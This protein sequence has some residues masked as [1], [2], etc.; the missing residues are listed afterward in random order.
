MNKFFI[1]II[2][3]LK[4]DKRLFSKDDNKLLKGELIS[5]ITKDDEKLLNLLASS[6]EVEKRF[7]KKIGKIT[8]FQKEKFLQLVTM[9]EF[10]PD[11]FTAFEVSIGLSDNKKFIS[12]QEDISLVFPHKDCILEGGQKKEDAKRNEIF[13]NT[14]LAPDEIDRLR[15]PKVLTNCKKF[16]KKGEH[17]IENIFKSDNL[18][19]KGNNLLA[20]YSLLP[21]Y[22]NEIKLIYID[23]P[24]NTGSDSFKYNDSFNHSSWLTFMK[25]RLEIALELLDD[26]GGI[27]ISIDDREFAYLKVLCDEIFGQNNFLGD[28]IWNST[29]SITNTA[30]ISVAHTHNLVYFKNINYIIKNRKE[31]RLPESGEGFFNPD[32]DPRGQ[33]KADP[34]QVG[35][36]RPNQQYKIK[37]PNTG[38]I[39]KP[40]DDCS[41]KNDFKKFQE[42]L[43]DNRIVFGTDGKAGPQRKRFLF[44]ALERGKVSKTIWDDVGT[45]TNG[46][47]HLNKLL[48]RNL[49][50][51]PKPETFI[52]KIVELATKENDIVLDFFAG[53]GTTGAVA[54]KMNRQYILIEQMDYVHRLPEARLKKVIEGEQGGISKLVNWHGGGSFVYTELLE[55][56]HKY[57]KELESAKNKLAVKKIKAKIEKEQFYKYQIDTSKFDNKK[58]EKLSEKEQ[59]E[60]LIDMLDMNTL[61]VNIDSINDTT[62]A[63]SKEDKELN[64]KFYNQK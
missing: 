64:K 53:S 31:F 15:E 46:T 7:F 22:R 12:A 24:Y 38:K 8:I 43:K 37:N 17:K 26:N 42:L 25:N 19:I 5:L 20:L 6:K 16:D 35:G 32:N 29:K 45:T 33:W 41:W 2:K 52:K 54:H 27:F 4:K 59:K 28:I 18:V 14:V 56:N 63:V 9:N 44:E 61:Y 47:Q 1:E 36:W 51:N 10:L 11:S 55:W 23:P 34:F 50:S 3:I 57:I 39:Y 58:F 30:I 40:N 49:F 62:F 21:N 13:Y 48:K 60:V